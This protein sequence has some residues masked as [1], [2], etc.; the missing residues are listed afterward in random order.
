MKTVVVT[1]VERAESTVID[2]LADLAD[3]GPLGQL[4]G[5]VHVDEFG[6]G[7][8]DN[9]RGE[10]AAG[11]DRRRGRIVSGAGDVGGAGQHLRPA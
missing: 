3:T 1:K 7:G 11:S 2:R 8:R 9:S 5:V 10:D 6:R 4:R